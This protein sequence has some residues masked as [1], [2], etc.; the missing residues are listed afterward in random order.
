MITYVRRSAYSN[1]RQKIAFMFLMM[2]AY[3]L[4]LL[5]YFPFFYRRG[6]DSERE[7][8]STQRNAIKS[9]QQGVSKKKPNET[10]G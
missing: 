6:S 2:A 9:S 7:D 8:M 1:N 10:A 5:L 3:D 4:K